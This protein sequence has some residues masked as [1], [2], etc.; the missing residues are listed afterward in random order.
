MVKNKKYK[1]DYTICYRN[2]QC[3]VVYKLGFIEYQDIRVE[4]I[5]EEIQYCRDT[6]E[7]IQRFVE[8]IKDNVIRKYKDLDKI[9]IRVKCF[10]KQN[11]IH[12]FVATIAD[13]IKQLLHIQ[14]NIEMYKSILVYVFYGE[15]RVFVGHLNFTDLL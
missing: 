9:R 15:E 3:N 10:D 1:M 2:I 7:Y 13:I 11:S 14:D 6:K 5:D 4:D 8:F 12:R